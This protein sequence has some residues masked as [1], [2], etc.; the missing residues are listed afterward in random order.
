MLYSNAWIATAQK[1]LTKYLHDSFK[2]TLILPKNVGCAF[3]THFT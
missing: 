3:V 2:Y 1:I